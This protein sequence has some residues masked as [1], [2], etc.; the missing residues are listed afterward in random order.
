MPIKFAPVATRMAVQE[1]LRRFTGFGKGAKRAGRGDD[2][3]QRKPWLPDT[4]SHEM[5]PENRIRQ[6]GKTIAGKLSFSLPKS[7][8]ASSIPTNDFRISHSLS[9]ILMQI[10]LSWD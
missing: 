9:G 6:C 8:T 1:S 10:L 5:T 7:A 3:A 2:L 4:G